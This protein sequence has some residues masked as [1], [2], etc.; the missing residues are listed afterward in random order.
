M[1]TAMATATTR[2]PKYTRFSQQQL[3][4]TRP[5]LTLKFTAKLT[6]IV[7][8]V[9]IAL[10]ATTL[11][12]VMGLREIRHRYDDDAECAQG[13][14]PTAAEKE[15]KVSYEGAGTTCEIEIEAP[16]SLKGPVYVYYELSNFF[17]NHRAFVRDLDYYQMA[18]SKESTKL[19]TT[20]QST[21]DGETIKPCG[22]QAWSYFNDSYAVELNDAAVD[23][24]S[25]G[26]AWPSDREY[27][28]GS[29]TAENLNTDAATRGGA[30]IDGP[31]RDDEHFV[32]WLRTAALSNF[33]K[34]W[35]KIDED[36]PKGTLIRVT[37]ENRYNTYKF[38]GRKSIVLA[39]N[40]WLGGRN[41]ALPILY[42]AN[43]G[44]CIITC[45]VCLILMKSVKKED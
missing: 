17:Q 38:D 7:G 18:G 2:K 13:F 3:W 41:L 31:V 32:T 44:I 26:I 42:F 15:A 24:D 25:S 29:Y 20:H 16:R 8:L 6:A 9:C 27:K 39:E 14:F 22:V 21:A 30:P 23:I 4:A 19:C 11:V 5:T 12:G 43:G 37:I 34:L 1:T 33:R 36:I 28:F 40:G 35:G 10:G 45:I